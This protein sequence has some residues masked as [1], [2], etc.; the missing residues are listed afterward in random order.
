MLHLELGRATAV[1]LATP[2]EIRS[3]PQ[4]L[5]RDWS[6]GIIGP[7]N[8]GFVHVAFCAHVYSEDKLIAV[9]RAAAIAGGQSN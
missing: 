3:R 7:D 1:P 9:L 4:I 2:C 5:A 6:A 8:V